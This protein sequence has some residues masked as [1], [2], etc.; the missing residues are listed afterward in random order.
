LLE[1]VS[2]AS[3]NDALRETITDALPGATRNDLDLDCDFMQSTGG[4][5]QLFLGTSLDQYVLN[6]AP[7][8]TE[9]TANGLLY[10]TYGADA[11]QALTISAPMINYRLWDQS[12]SK[13]AQRALVVGTTLVAVATAIFGGLAL[14]L[15]G[16]SLGKG[17]GHIVT[18][19]ARSSTRRRKKQRRVRLPPARPAAGIDTAPE[20]PN[21]H[22]CSC[23]V[24][25]R[26]K[27]ISP[28]ASLAI[29]GVAIL[30]LAI[31]RLLRR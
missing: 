26:T 29:A 19:V 4:Q 12:D 17:N 5:L 15:A 23:E 31:G 8:P 24:G 6:A 13:D 22:A 1:V 11:G 9:S 25:P 3:V 21:P 27:R 20:D 16:D 10:G 30:G 28:A 18:F 2:L 7:E 14:S